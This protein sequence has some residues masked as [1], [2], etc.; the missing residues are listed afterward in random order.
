VIPLS[1]SRAAMLFYHKD[2]VRPGGL[3]NTSALGSSI[4]LWEDPTTPA[5]RENLRPDTSEPTLL[6]QYP[7][8]QIGVQAFV[9]SNFLYAY[10]I[11]YQRSGNELIVARVPLEQALQRRAWRFYV[12]DGNWSESWQ[13]AMPVSRGFLGTVEWNWHLGKFVYIWNNFLADTLSLSIADRPEGPWSL[14][15]EIPL[16]P[17]SNRK[18]LGIAHVIA[19]PELSRERGRV[20]YVTYQCG[21]GTRLVELV[22]Q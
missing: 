16:G 8:P 21:T 14:T 19:H 1:G 13:Q 3:E 12:G 17:R 5:V 18:G 11:H 4:A 9:W 6:F 20:Q 22:F 15:Q 10:G 2:F 7:E